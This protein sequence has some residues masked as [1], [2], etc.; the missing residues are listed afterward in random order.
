[1][2]NTLDLKWDHAEHLYSVQQE[3]QKAKQKEKRNVEEYF[4]FLS[5]ILPTSTGESKERI[6]DKQFTL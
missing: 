6:T 4:T 2:N 5:D 3:A 1:M